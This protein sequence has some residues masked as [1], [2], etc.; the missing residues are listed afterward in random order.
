MVKPIISGLGGYSQG[1]PTTVY[2][3]G[4]TPQPQPVRF[5]AGLTAYPGE[6]T[7]TTPDT[8]PSVA[9]TWQVDWTRDTTLPGQ[10]S[11]TRSSGATYLGP[12]IR[13]LSASSNGPRI[14]YDGYGNPL[15]LLIEAEQRIN[16]VWNSE[17]LSTWAG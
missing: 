2:S 8:A 3:P 17:T 14:E 6:V 4:I 16:L 7:P 1:G 9:P 10:L 12:A 13:R 5:T 11:L 15:G